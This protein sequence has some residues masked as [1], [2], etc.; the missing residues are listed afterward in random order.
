M[1]VTLLVCEVAVTTLILDTWLAAFPS[2]SMAEP[3]DA[4]LFKNT[5]LSKWIGPLDANPPPLLIA[6]HESIRMCVAK[7]LDMSSAKR[8]PPTVALQRE[9][10]EFIK[11]NF[12]PRTQL[13][14]EIVPDVLPAAICSPLGLNAA[15]APNSFSEIC[16]KVSAVD[17]SPSLISPVTAFLQL[18]G[19]LATL[20]SLVHSITLKGRVLVTSH[21][22][23]VLSSDADTIDVPSGEKRTLF[24]KPLWAFSVL[25]LSSRVTESQTLIAL[26]QDPETIFEPSG[27]KLTDEMLA[28]CAFRFTAIRSSVAE[29]Q[30]LMVLS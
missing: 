4:M 30:T 13:H 18:G 12:P 11:T 15:A 24:K 10:L 16:T 9:R 21:T 14:K 8:P 6:V 2:T 17:S 1:D 27:E 29:S 23:I 5:G 26:S 3:D 28:V 20:L 22:L 25:A 7:V 19:R